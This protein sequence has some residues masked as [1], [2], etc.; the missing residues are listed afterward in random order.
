M[1]TWITEER[2]MP[3]GGDLRFVSVSC[4]HERGFH[5]APSATETVGI[6]EQGFVVAGFGETRLTRMGWRRCWNW[7]AR[8][9][10]TLTWWA[11]D[12]VLTRITEAIPPR[13]I[14]EVAVLMRTV[15]PLAGGMPSFRGA[16][17]L[18][19]RR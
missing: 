3:G 6:E 1:A 16:V 8:S 10:V 9:M 14:P 15:A 18:I 19:G 11:K 17:E 13:Y 4:D 12:G 7:L 2:V 5:A